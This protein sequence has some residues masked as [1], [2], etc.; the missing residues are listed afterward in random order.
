M[1]QKR[2]LSHSP[3]KLIINTIQP[4]PNLTVNKLLYYSSRIIT[5][6]FIKLQEIIPKMGAREQKASKDESKITFDHRSEV[7]RL[8]DDVFRSDKEKLHLFTQ[9]LRR[10]ALYKKAKIVHK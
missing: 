9:M 2:P 10:N 4:S 1:L 5:H 6:I 3:I 8:R 7:E